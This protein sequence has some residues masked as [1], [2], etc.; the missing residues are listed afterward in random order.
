MNRP[1]AC[2][3][4]ALLV[5]APSPLLA[6]DAASHPR[7]MRGDVSGTVGWVS[8]NKGDLTFDQYNDWRSQAGFSL[9]AGWYWTDHHQTRVETSG[10]TETTVYSAVPAPF[11][12]GQSFIPVR[13]TFASHRI[14]ITQHYQF[15]RN[16]WVHPF[17]GAG[18][19]FVRER[20][21]G[22]DDPV[23]SY[24]PIT[25]QTR[26]VR[27]AVEHTAHDEY[28]ARGVLT[29]G[30][31]A[32]MSRKVFAVTDLRVSIGSRRTEDVQWRFG[33]GADF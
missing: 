16:E 15:R 30:M 10:T 3:L 32:Y 31:K 26:L 21:S 17:L 20:V 28:T 13:R 5:F 19:D 8:T 29:A 27:D 25:R 4:M 33:L 2:A 9:G 23:F 11:V 1:Q 24:D 7:L 12:G 6:Q 22:K 18:V 14:S